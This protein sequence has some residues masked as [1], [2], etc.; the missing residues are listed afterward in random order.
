MTK[1]YSFLESIQNHDEKLVGSVKEA[2][3]LIF[4]GLG[5]E[6]ALDDADMKLE[7]NTEEKDAE[8]ASLMTEDELKDISEQSIAS[9]SI[10]EDISSDSDELGDEDVN[11]DGLDELVEE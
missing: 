8:S 5:T 3:K 11:I 1:F 7:Q 2:Y 4:E 6:E 9:D 10:E